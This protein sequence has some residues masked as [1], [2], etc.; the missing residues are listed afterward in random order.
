[1]AKDEKDKKLRLNGDLRQLNKG[2]KTNCS[3]SPTPNKVMQSLKY[4][5]KYFIKTDLL[6]GYHQIS[7][8]IK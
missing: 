6:Q 4:A 7:L 3:I 2:V 1:M 8:H 5:S